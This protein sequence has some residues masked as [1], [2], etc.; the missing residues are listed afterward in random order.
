MVSGTLNRMPPALSGSMHEDR[1]WAGGPLRHVPCTGDA[2][3]ATCRVKSMRPRVPCGP[4]HARLHICWWLAA[5]TPRSG[6]L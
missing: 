3:R 2:H 4:D 5:A 6:T 1:R